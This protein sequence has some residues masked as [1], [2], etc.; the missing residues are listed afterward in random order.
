MLEVAIS[1]EYYLQRQLFCGF[2]E[3]ARGAG[4]LAELGAG[5]RLFYESA[6]HCLW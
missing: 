6:L 5:A 1:G 2:H 4:S 3:L